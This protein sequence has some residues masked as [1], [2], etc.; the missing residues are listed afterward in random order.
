VGGSELA[1][2]R[3]SAGRARALVREG[4]DCDGFDDRL[5]L[6]LTRPVRGS[7]NRKG[8]SLSANRKGEPLRDGAVER[9]SDS[10]FAD[11]FENAPNAM[12]LIATDGR[13][14]QAN[15]SLCRMLGFTKNE[16]QALNSSNITHPDDLQ[17]E[18]EQKRRLAAADIGRYELVQRYV[19][20]GGEAIW[21]RLSVSAMRRNPGGPVHFIAQVESVAPHD[22]ADAKDSH[23][24]SLSR[25]GDVTLS[26]F[27]E[28]GNSLTPLML[29]AEMIMEQSNSNDIRES[30]H[31]IFKAARRI[32]FT[33]RR[34]RGIEDGRP[35]AYLGQSRMLDLRLMPPPT[36]EEEA[37]LR[38]PG[39][40]RP[41]SRA[42]KG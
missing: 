19:R 7:H 16:L 1:G 25:F 5:S 8:A 27:H 13:I 29:N 21:I 41:G 17:T 24:T 26:A 22:P 10:L 20:S 34:L 30:A 32:A 23:D 4:P 3:Q 33:L 35:V 31:Q 11:A 2:A 42:R 37:V 6:I 9:Q 39:V 12:A 28:I 36:P 14:I 15:R 18:V 40:A 38:G